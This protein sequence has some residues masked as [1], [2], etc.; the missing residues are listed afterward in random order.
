MMFLLLPIQLPA[1]RDKKENVQPLLVTTKSGFVALGHNGN[2]VNSRELR[3]Y[4]QGNGAIFQTSTDSELILHLIAHSK[5]E[6][7]LDQIKDALS[8]I[9]GAF[10]LVIE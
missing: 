1:L 10:S 5:K 4:L 2:L 8:R 3:S 6:T 9:R 7:I